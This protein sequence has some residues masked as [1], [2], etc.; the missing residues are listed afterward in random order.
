M[1][2]LVS[3]TEALSPLEASP[4]VTRVEGFLDNT[5]DIEPEYYR[6]K[7]EQV[8]NWM[9]GNLLRNP[10]ED[11][12]TALQE[13]HGEVLYDVLQR[14][15]GKRPKR[16]DS[17]SVKGKTTAR[18][19]QIL[20]QKYSILL[21]LLQFLRS[22][23]CCLSGVEPSFLLPFREAVT[24]GDL[25]DDISEESFNKTAKR[26][27]LVL[28][29]EVIRVFFLSTITA[30]ELSSFVSDDQ[31]YKTCW[32]S[33]KF[34]ECLGSSNVYSFEES[35]LLQFVRTTCAADV[36]IDGKALERLRLESYDDLRD[37]RPLLVTLARHIPFVEELWLK[38][39]TGLVQAPSL[40]QEYRAVVM[41]L[42]GI[43][44]K[45]GMH[46]LPTP[47]AYLD[48][49]QADFVL[50]VSSVC[51]LIRR[52]S[53]FV[54]VLF[55]GKLLSNQEQ[56]IEVQNTSTFSR[57]YNVFLSNPAF[58]TAAED[59]T[60]QPNSSSTVS[61]CT[62][63]KYFRKEEGWCVLSDHTSCLPS[64]QVPLVFRLISSPNSEPLK[65]IHITTN[66]YDPL[67]E[68]IFI[69]NPFKDDCV[70]A[71]HVSQEVFCDGTLFREADVSKMF[72]SAFLVSVDVLPLRKV[73]G[74]RLAYT[75][76]PLSR[77]VYKL[78]VTFRAENFGEF[79]YLII[80]TCTLPRP[81]SENGLVFRVEKGETSVVSLPIKP[82]NT[83]LEKT[84]RLYE[85]HN[86]Q[87]RRFKTLPSPP[88]LVNCE[89]E[90]SFVG[91]DLSSPNPFLEPS[92]KFVTLTEEAKQQTTTFRFKPKQVGTYK[93]FILLSSPVDVR[94]LPFCGE[95]VTPG[96][97]G[98]LKF[99]CAARRTI[100]QEIAITNNSST[101]WS[102]K[103]T[104]SETVYFSG[105]K[106]FVVQ[107]GKM[108]AYAL[109]Y[110]PPWIT[111]EEVK[112]KL[113]LYNATTGQKHVFDL[114]GKAEAPLA[115]E[116]LSVSCQA[117]EK[118]NLEITV[119]NVFSTDCKYIVESDLSFAKGPSELMVLRGATGRYHLAVTPTVGGEYDGKII[120]RSEDRYVWYNLH[121]A[122]APPE[123]EGTVRLKTDERTG[124]AGDVTIGTRPKRHS[125]SMS[126]SSVP[127]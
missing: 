72:G 119:P 56:L 104:L 3:T 49:D 99:S 93:G 58:V 35:M 37:A 28:M 125:S 48:F 33:K 51:L 107:Q 50:F 110:H 44:E 114:F 80:G 84:C 66:L 24:R 64:E 17:E 13:S 21:G 111:K 78:K 53:S 126:V 9:N 127:G 108:R 60:V 68:D 38:G 20:A 89:Y 96:E 41:L 15:C 6:V 14:L 75:F 76:A 122:V 4:F 29:V 121:V 100:T 94:V 55:D 32:G 86:R 67:N 73:E 26:M 25:S 115:E 31:G 47:D 97:K 2:L 92:E 46:H 109:Q 74:G 91:E 18:N 103:A 52:Y 39:E 77:G 34:K 61:L 88:S 95:C 105:L 87:T 30:T 85:E 113:E 117:R 120:F 123:K 63:A 23:G 102:F 82:V 11:L 1:S 106:D 5:D 112:E 81:Q 36:S 118:V 10:C 69:E 43:L 19:Q 42:F 124:V 71:M 90:V 16:A 22:N 8:E 65:T 98:V 12:L 57:V 116:D 62:S 83:L 59:V 45:L 54:D 70:V 101:D 27:W 40:R 7:F 79:S